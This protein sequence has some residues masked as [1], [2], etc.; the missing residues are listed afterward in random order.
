MAAARRKV[1]VS[2]GMDHNDD[3]RG[4]ERVWQVSLGKLA[5]GGC[6]GDVGGFNVVV[7]ADLVRDDGE[8]EGALL[9]RCGGVRSAR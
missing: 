8:R 5:A 6:A 2:L 7:G 4:S 3:D 9:A 1:E